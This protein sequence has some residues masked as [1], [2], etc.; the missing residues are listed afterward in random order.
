MPVLVAINIE[1]DAA[2]SVLMMLCIVSSLGGFRVK[3]GIF[4]CLKIPQSSTATFMLSGRELLCTKTFAELCSDCLISVVR[5]L[6]TGASTINLEIGD[7]DRMT[8]KC[9]ISQQR[10]VVLS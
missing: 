6:R 9:L 8:I 2:S 5:P 10:P 1:V 3:W 4:K 7:K